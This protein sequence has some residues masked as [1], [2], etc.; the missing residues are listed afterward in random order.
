[1]LEI[2]NVK[3]GDI[4]Y[5][6]IILI[7]GL[8][9]GENSKNLE[10]IDSHGKANTWSILNNQFKLFVKLYPGRNEIKLKTFQSEVILILFRHLKPLNSK[11]VRIFYVVCNDD[12]N[13]GEFQSLDSSRNKIQNALK[14]IDLNIRLLQ[15]FMSEEIFKKYKTRKTFTLKC[16]LNECDENVEIFR[17]NL[18]LMKAL[19]MSSDEIF[20]YLLD[21]IKKRNSNRECKYIAILSF[22][23][24]IPGQNEDIFKD[25]KGYCALASDC[26]AVYGTACLFT[27]PEELDELESCCSDMRKVDSSQMNDSAFRNTYSDCYS[28]TLG[29][30]LHEFSHLLD[31]GHDSEGIMHRGFDDLKLFF[32]IETTCNCYDEFENVKSN[33]EDIQKISIFKTQNENTHKSEIEFLVRKFCLFKT[34]GNNE[35]IYSQ[36][37]SCFQSIRTDHKSKECNCMKNCFYTKSNLNILFYHKWLNDFC[38]KDEGSISFNCINECQYEIKCT[39]DLVLYELRTNQRNLTFDSGYPGTTSLTSNF[40]SIKQNNSNKKEYI[41]EINLNNLKQKLFLLFGNETRNGCNNL[42]KYKLNQLNNDCRTSQ[43]FNI[44]LFLLDS[45]GCCLSKKIPIM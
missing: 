33:N 10:C 44:Y 5:N 16:D 9:F 22:T 35:L 3:P 37:S 29:S 43:N 7:Y 23:R 34:T 36:K 17:S 13:C 45:K 19:E 39:N 27:W 24:Y 2:L 1:M 12:P 28:T 38:S 6:S 21:E 14:R 30:L 42:S 40:I 41:F 11:H 20:L 31:L 25:T 26:L 18:K 4:F 15:T 8:S 32:N